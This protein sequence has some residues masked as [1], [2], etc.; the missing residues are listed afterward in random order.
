MKT[1]ATYLDQKRVRIETPQGDRF[2]LEFS[3]GMNYLC[4]QNY[5]I[6]FTNFLAL[7]FDK[8]YKGDDKVIRGEITRQLLI[9]NLEPVKSF[10]C[11]PILN[12]LSIGSR[13]HELRE[14]KGMDL[15]TL[16]CKSGIKPNTLK[17]IEAGKFSVD[18]DVLYSIA[19]GLGMKID[20]VELNENDNHGSTSDLFI[21]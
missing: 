20:F 16:A 9:H 8:F 6:P 10:Y 7:L 3:N 19:Q 15:L 1:K 4:E 13:I 5:N 11:D 2:I 17:R 21:Q 14:Q 12:R 18:L